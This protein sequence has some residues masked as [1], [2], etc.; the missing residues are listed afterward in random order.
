MNIIERNQKIKSN[1]NCIFNKYYQNNVHVISRLVIIMVFSQ[2]LWSKGIQK[3]FEW[4]N[5]RH[6]SIQQ[7]LKY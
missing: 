4:I 5:E 3:L 2:R 7:Y 1:L 6:M